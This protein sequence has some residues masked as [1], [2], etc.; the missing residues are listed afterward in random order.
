MK[1]INKTT[2]KYLFPLVTAGGYTVLALLVLTRPDGVYL[3]GGAAVGGLLLALG[4]EI[5]K[6]AQRDRDGAS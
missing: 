5:R 2:F 4:T 1:P 3:Y 6:A